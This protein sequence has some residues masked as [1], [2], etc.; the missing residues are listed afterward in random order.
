MES[1]YRIKK[2]LR[3]PLLLSLIVS[4][5]V[6][7]DVFHRGYQTRV[8]V[9]ASLLVALFYL[10]TINNLVKRVTIDETGVSIRGVFGT[11]RAVF[12]HIKRVDGIRFGARQFIAITEKRNIL[13]PNT[14]A[15]FDSLIDDILAKVPQETVAEGIVSMRENIVSRKSDITM[16]WIIVIILLFCNILIFFPS[17]LGL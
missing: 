3:V 5:P 2:A 12:D 16:A 1:V 6:F 4:L 15:G 14:F 9:M 17:L 7:W 11:S 13:I 8:V 10:F